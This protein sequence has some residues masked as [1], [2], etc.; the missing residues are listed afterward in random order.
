MTQLETSPPP[1]SSQTRLPSN[2]RN[3]CALQHKYH[4]HL[5][6]GYSGAGDF[7]L[8]TDQLSPP[9]FF[10]RGVWPCS[11]APPPPPPPQPPRVE[12]LT[13]PAEEEGAVLNPSVTSPLQRGTIEASVA[14][15]RVHCTHSAYA[16]ID[17]P[18]LRPSQSLLW[19]AAPIRT[20]WSLT[21]ILG[22]E[23]GSR[24]RPKKAMQTFAT[25]RALLPGRLPRLVTPAALALVH[26]RRPGVPWS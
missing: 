5:S 18:P 21:M 8:V 26:C 12:S 25:A 16:V 15:F 19:G 22:P 9:F 11:S 17:L 24:D 3:P 14:K 7:G 10:T 23:A 6:H 2:D 4:C 13:A 1:P 20:R